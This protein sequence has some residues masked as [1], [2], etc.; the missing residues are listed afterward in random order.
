MLVE[1]TYFITRT[2]SRASQ[3]VVQILCLPSQFAQSKL[4]VW[5]LLSKFVI[6]LLL[7]VLRAHVVDYRRHV[8]CERQ[9]RSVLTSDQFRVVQH[10]WTVKHLLEYDT[11]VS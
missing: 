11:D 4:D 7:Q 10:V 8:R 3:L 5:K 6:Q 2:K 9:Q 1:G